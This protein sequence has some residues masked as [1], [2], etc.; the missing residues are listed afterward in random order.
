MSLMLYVFIFLLVGQVALF[1]LMMYFTYK[2]LSE[3]RQLLDSNVITFKNLIKDLKI[4]CQK[5]K[6][7]K[8]SILAK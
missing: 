6:R 4:V 5:K 2:L 8:E 3:Y 7:N 1:T